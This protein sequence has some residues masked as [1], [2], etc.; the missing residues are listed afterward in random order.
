MKKILLNI[1]VLSALAGGIGLL[2]S[3]LKGPRDWRTAVSWV[4]WLL[5]VAVAIGT[6]VAESNDDDEAGRNAEEQ[7]RR[8]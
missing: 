5:G 7:G 6:V 2:R 8:R 4:S 3:T 1:G